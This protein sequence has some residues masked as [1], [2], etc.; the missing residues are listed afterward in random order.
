MTPKL[1]ADLLKMLEE[2][3]ISSKQ[4]KDVFIKVIEEEKTPESI[5]KE[6]GMSQ[7]TDE[8]ELLKIVEEILEENPTQIEAYKQQPRLLDYF[9]GQMMK[10]TRGKANPSL[11]SK[12]LKQELDKK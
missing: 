4:S 12:L 2:G 6:S 10:Q 11:A 1:L 8:N 7:I 9:I 5:I 3:K